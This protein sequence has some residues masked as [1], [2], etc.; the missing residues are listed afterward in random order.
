MLSVLLRGQL[1]VVYPTGFFLFNLG[2]L[3]A[4]AL[5]LSR[6]AHVYLFGRQVFECLFIYLLKQLRVSPP[7]RQQRRVRILFRCVLHS[8][9]HHLQIRP[10]CSQALLVNLLLRHPQCF[11]Y[12]LCVLQGR[13][14][15]HGR[16]GH[17]GGRLG[18][19]GE[20]PPLTRRASGA[21]APCAS[22]SPPSLERQE[23]TGSFIICMGGNSAWARKKRGMGATG[24]GAV[25]GSRNT[26]RET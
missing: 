7:L 4:L 5:P 23:S 8:V 21:A 2:C 13:W 19:S 12:V 6:L 24:G 16:F 22:C 10:S 1:A 25:S 11:I 17:R 9:L 26:A 18:C 15:G 3:A 14:R 20:R